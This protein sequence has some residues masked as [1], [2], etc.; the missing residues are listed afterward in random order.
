[1]FTYLRHKSDKTGLRKELLISGYCRT[2]CKYQP[3]TDICKLCQLFF[4]ELF[5]VSFDVKQIKN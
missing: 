1:M 3:P 5:Y 4:T 2:N